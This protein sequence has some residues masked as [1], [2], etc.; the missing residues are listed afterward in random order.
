MYIYKLPSAAGS[1]ISVTSAATGLIDLIETASSGTV[2]N[3]VQGANAFDI[4]V[5]DGDIRMLMDSNTPTATNGIL[6]SSGTVHRFRGVPLTQALFIRVGG[7]N[8]ACSVQ[9]GRSDLD[10]SSSSAAYDVTLEAGA[11]EI[12]SIDGTGTQDSAVDAQGL[13]AMAEA[14]TFDGAALPNTVDEGDATRIAG[15]KSGV[16][17]VMLV[18]EDGSAQPATDT[19]TD[20]FKIYNSSPLSDQHAEST[21]VDNTNETD[22]TT[23]Y[24]VDMD[25]Y[26][27]MGAQLIISGG[28]G[29]MTVTVEG[30]LQD[31][32]TAASSCTYGDISTE[33]GAASWTATTILQ[34]Q[35][36]AY[37]YLRFKT[38]S[39]TGGS[40]DADITIYFKKLYS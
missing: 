34:G 9:V 23:Y 21:L 24:Y 12:G 26:N 6:L 3:L 4:T 32:G 15:T 37:K 20:T 7:S 22:A 16:Q 39:S 18:N 11:V 31:D 8:V 33:F 25:G 10:E 30:S 40:D 27:A 28:S 1:K 35:D 38:V 14:K 5:E 2:S 36:L 19:G 29:T 13:Q 17:Y